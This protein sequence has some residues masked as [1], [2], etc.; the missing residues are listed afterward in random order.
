MLF[1]SELVSGLLTGVPCF[2]G[3]VSLICRMCSSAAGSV[4]L[5]LQCRPWPPSGSGLVNPSTPCLEKRM[6][7]SGEW[8]TRCSSAKAFA[9]VTAK[10]L[11]CIC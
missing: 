6:N 11:S 8:V 7:W 1:D 10:F 9:Y 2:H 4:W 5:R 3:L